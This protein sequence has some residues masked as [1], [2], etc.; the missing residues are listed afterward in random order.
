MQNNDLTRIVR[1]WK[2]AKSFLGKVRGHRPSYSSTLFPGVREHATIRRQ[3]FEIVALGRCWPSHPY[4]P[5][6]APLLPF[7]SSSSRDQPPGCAPFPLFLHDAPFL[8][9]EQRSQTGSRYSLLPRAISTLSLDEETKRKFTQWSS[10]LFLVSNVYYGECWDEDE[11]DGRVLE[12]KPH[13]DVEIIWLW[14]FYGCIGSDI[15]IMV[16]DAKM[17][18]DEVEYL[19][20]KY[21]YIISTLFF[22]LTNVEIQ[23]KQIFFGL[24]CFFNVGR[25]V[26]AN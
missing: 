17:H 13:L 19:F 2:R 5:S 11:Q 15:R 23:L 14:L 18:S 22:F 4:L 3:V 12:K 8:N 20:C 26:S 9:V 6:R 16:Y 24:C 21:T 25:N 1:V 10:S 7:R